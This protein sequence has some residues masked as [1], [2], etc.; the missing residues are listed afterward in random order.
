MEVYANDE[1]R[2]EVLHRWWKQNGTS[3]IAGALVGALAIVGWNL[4]ENN[5]HAV[6]LQAS[7]LYQQLLLANRENRGEAA[8]KLSERLI[9]QYPSTAYGD[10]ARL[11]LARLKVEAGDVQAA[12]QA[13][14]A[15]LSKTGDDN[16]KLLA[17]LRLAQV[18]LA[19]DDK[20]AALRQL[21]GV[22]ADKAGQF[23]G[24]YQE[25]RGDVLVASGRADEARAA[26][27]KALAL[28]EASP[29]LKLKLNDL[30]AR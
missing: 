12:R 24:V 2:L 25:L 30:P 29:L 5:Q 28:T 23:Q 10:Y 15:L 1:E 16:L 7:N 26:Y 6:N 27:E 3:I 9:Q 11:F 18:M 21:D 4:W 20:E 19:L 8:I 13:L 14:E 22:T 17:R